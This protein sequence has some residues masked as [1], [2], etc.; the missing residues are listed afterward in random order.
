MEKVLIRPGETEL[1]LNRVVV[2]GMG[3]GFG[4]TIVLTPV[5][6]IKCRLQVY[7]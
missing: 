6:L 2:A 3:S 4:S 7:N 1:P 5:E